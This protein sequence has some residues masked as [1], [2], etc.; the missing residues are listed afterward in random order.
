MAAFGLTL[1]VFGIWTLIG[2]ALVCLLN[3]GRNLIRNALL[4]P[5]AGAST[6]M[7]AI[8]ECN[9][10][11]LPVRACGPAVTLLCGLIAAVLIW[12]LRLPVPWRRLAPFLAVVAAGALLVGYPLLLHGFDWFSYGNDDMANYVLGAGAFLNR[13]YLDSFDPRLILE[14]RDMG[15][16]Q[17]LP[18]ILSGVRCGSELTLAWVMS[19]TGLTGHQVFMPVIVALHLVLICAAGAL[20]VRGRNTRLAGLVTCGWMAVSSLVALGTVYQLIAQVFGMGLLA[21]AAALLLEP[22]RGKSRA[23]VKRAL[24]A[25]VFCAAIGVAYPEILPFLV[26]PFGLAHLLALLRRKEAIASLARA[27]AI[28]VAATVVLWNTFADCVPAF[29]LHQ[30]GSGLRA[31]SAAEL[32]FPYYLVPSGLATYWGILPIAQTM[33]RPLLDLAI[34]AGTMLLAV[35]AWVAVRQ[36]WRG[37]PAALIAVVMFILAIRLAWTRSDFGL[38]KLAMYSQPFV[39]GLL[40]RAW[41]RRGTQPPDGGRIRFVRVLPIAIVAALGLS[42]QL[43]YVSLSA[44]LAG[45]KGGFVEVPEASSRHLVSRLQ[46][47][48][49]VPRRSLV[50]SDTSNVVLAKVEAA[51]FA[52]SRQEYTAQD[53]FTS[54]NW[55]IMRLA[56]W[57]ADLVSPGYAG[58]SRQALLKWHDML[59][60]EEFEMHGGRRNPFVVVPGRDPSIS[61]YSLLVTGPVL[62]ALNRSQPHDTATGSLVTLIPSEQI[63]NHL[64]QVD[65]ELGKNYYHAFRARGEGRVALFQL[66]PDY[67]YPGR[68]MS[69]VGRV[70]LFEV[71]QPSPGLRLQMEYTASLQADG[72]NT[73][74]DAQAIGAQRSAFGGVGRGSARLFSPPLDPQT[75]AGRRYIAL[76]MGANGRLFPQVRNGLMRWFGASI[77]LDP[78]RVTGFVRDISAVATEEYE[79]LQAPIS[80]ADFPGGL[81]KKSLEYSGIYED[82]WVAEESF[83]GLRQPSQGAVLSV[84]VMMPALMQRPVALHVLVDGSPVAQAVLRPGD[85]ELQ[86]I[87]EGP[88]ARR[89]IDLRFDGATALPAPDSRMVSAQLKF[90]G[91]SGNGSVREE[92][93]APPI[94][95]GDHWY[96][97]ERFQGQTFRWVDNNARFALTLPARRSGQLEIDV[98]P[99]PG[100]AGKPLGLRLVL[101]DGGTRALPIVTGRDVLRVPLS[102]AGG[103]NHLSLG[104]DGGGLAIASDPRKLNFRVFTLTWVPRL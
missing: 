11:G 34:V 38:Y 27:T 61:D 85:N 77:P 31:A 5:V 32:L 96:P 69:A 4:A 86:A 65:S 12:R 8:F 74:P 103:I 79:S 56:S 87:L 73:I 99:G 16:A 81:D 62:S 28:T 71:L 41:T 7:L 101:P 94:A 17:W 102:L 45:A 72:R 40:A 47:L 80:V 93:A 26:L 24:L 76:D 83:L 46:S 64:V 22:I 50:V 2:W 92:I 66:E 67:F 70:I 44:G 13:G 42:A 30:A 23:A 18:M 104:A 49:R 98:E 3:G 20:L 35:A 95:I 90:V 59:R 82:G 57:Y 54:P 21:G 51:H 39:I 58:R 97:F 10:W 89:R 29:L 15:M 60:H 14:N 55:S 37:Q 53:F 88:P 63:R 68:T 91:F 75:I 1:A 33:E 36:A 25:A 19:L 52:P 6:L 48:S 100:M 84:R 43:H 78:R 9:R